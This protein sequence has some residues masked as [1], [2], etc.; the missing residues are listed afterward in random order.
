M[1]KADVKMPDDFL[2]KLSKLFD[3]PIE[4]FFKN[5]QITTE[6]PNYNV[7]AEKIETVKE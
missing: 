4:E 1:A 2:L 7:W 5:N 3:V 6:F